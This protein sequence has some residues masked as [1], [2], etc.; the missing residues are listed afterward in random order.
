MENSVLL[1]TKTRI[2]SYCFDIA[3][4]CLHRLH[5]TPPTKGSHK[6]HLDLGMS[7]AMI[8][9]HKYVHDLVNDLHTKDSE[10]KTYHKII[11]N[12]DDGFK[13]IHLAIPILKKHPEIQPILFLTG[14]QIR[15]DTTALPLVAF[16]HWCADK[17]KDPNKTLRTLGFD[18]NSLKLISESKQRRLLDSKGID[19]NPVLEK[20]I[21]DKEIKE[22]INNNW[23]IGYHGPEHFDLREMVRPTLH[24]KL[25]TD[26]NMI[27]QL[28][29]TPWIAWPEGRWNN[30]IVAMAKDVGFERQFGLNEKNKPESNS[31]IIDRILWK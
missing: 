6:I 14:K 15:G 23:L 31:L 22:L 17:R 2:Y 21:G 25:V 11:I 16:Y 29:Y 3:L 5:L 24:K 12:F 30:E 9:F 1:T 4:P 26:Y 8:S 28:G 7:C 10:C 27:V 13:D 19:T 18:R 20:M